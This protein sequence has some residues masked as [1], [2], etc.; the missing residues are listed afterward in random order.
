MFLLKL[1]EDKSYPYIQV[2]EIISKILEFVNEQIEG[3]F[4]LRWV[5]RGNWILEY[6]NERAVVQ[7]AKDKAQRELERTADY[8]KELTGNRPAWG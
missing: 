2:H 1:E 6:D 3:E 7:K 4:R 5:R 8:I